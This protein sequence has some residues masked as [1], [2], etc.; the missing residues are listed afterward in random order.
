MGSPKLALPFGS[1]TMLARVVRIVGETVSPVVVVAAADQELPELP[2]GIIVA[3]D[4]V[5]GHGPLAGLV[6][7]VAALK[8]RAE[9]KRR[10][11]LNRRAEAAFVSSCDVPLLKP[12]FIRAMV[13]A[14][15]PH[16]MAVP[17]DE[18]RTYPLAAVYR[19]SL[20]PRLRQLLAERR[21][22]LQSLANEFDARL[23]DVA[24]LRGV[25][26]ELDSLRNINTPAEYQ[27]ALA[28]VGISGP[29]PPTSA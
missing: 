18:E 6:T 22:R 2:A 16:E 26:P 15:G 14:L 12:A 4:E 13:D 19:V 5:A 29:P 27:A 21:L 10:A 28:A 1:E 20:E 17:S 25:D 9:L 8:G 11:E 3:R 24:E 7:G 23:V